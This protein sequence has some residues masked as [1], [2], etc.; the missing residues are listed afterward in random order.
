MHLAQSRAGGILVVHAGGGIISATRGK[1]VEAYQVHPAAA[2]GR[3]F[4]C[5]K[6]HPILLHLSRI[7][8]GWL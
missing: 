1:N 7:L 6:F 3:R 4:W 8:F 2:G 5:A